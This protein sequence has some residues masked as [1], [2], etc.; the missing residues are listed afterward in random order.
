MSEEKSIRFGKYVLV[1]RIGVGG[2]AEVFKAKWHGAEGFE[3]MVAIKRILPHLV[4]DGDF[5]KMFID[6]AKIA[7]QLNHPNIVAIHDLGRAEGTLFIAMEFVPGK[8]LRALYDYEEKRKGR[9]DIGIGCHVVM[10]MCEALHHAHFATGPRGEPLQVIHRD[11]SPQ[12]VLLSFDGEVKVADFGL[13]KARGRMVQTQAGVVKGKLA[14]MSP[15]QLKGDPIDHR[16][17]V[18]GLGIVLFELLSGQRLFLGPSDMDTLRRVYEARVPP[19]RELNPLVTEELEAVVRKALAKDRE[20]RYATAL[21]LHDDL[22]ALAYGQGFYRGA[23][24]LRQY[25][26]EA[27]PDAAPPPEVE[28][29]TFS[30]APPPARPPP[31]P[32]PPPSITVRPPALR[33]EE[34]LPPPPEEPAEPSL[35]EL[36]AAD[37]QLESSQLA[38]AA[39]IEQHAI[40]QLGG[41]QQGIAQQGIAQQGIA[42]HAVEQEPDEEEDTP[43]ERPPPPQAVI[44]TRA[45]VTGRPPESS[46]T[47]PASLPSTPP[48]IYEDE[49]TMQG[50]TA[51]RPA[52][53]PD[54]LASPFDPMEWGED[55]TTS[56]GAPALAD[57]D[58]D[59]WGEEDRTAI[60]DPETRTG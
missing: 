28:L 26:R 55:E 20:Q 10:K 31:P 48:G 37:V 56:H 38:Q 8:D 2:M 59:P 57:D 29:P 23:S 24:A 41:A 36:S 13:A 60:V 4:E 42:Q 11:V 17:D 43:T 18:F 30:T 16:V 25:L 19:M 33:R 15:E 12:N 53:P 5:V 9:T 46:G 44:V 49:P 50:P 14:Y 58:D 6:E 22:Q 52:P 39:A 1:E 40:A 21:E 45:I 47:V 35:Y 54:E 34:V 7:V 27:F 51:T 3:R 32:A